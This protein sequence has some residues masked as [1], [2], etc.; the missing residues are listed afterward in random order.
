[1]ILLHDIF[2]MER[3]VTRATTND[4]HVVTPYDSLKKSGECRNRFL[5]YVVLGASRSTSKIAH[6]ISKLKANDLS[7][8]SGIKY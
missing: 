6:A 5:V 4:R 2:V 8:L 1:M 7:R 3:A